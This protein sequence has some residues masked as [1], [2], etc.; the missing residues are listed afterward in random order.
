VVKASWPLLGG[1]ENA[2]GAEMAARLE[3]ACVKQEL[4]CVQVQS[5]QEREV[6]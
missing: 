6:W 5:Q 3:L 1:I 4:V 2:P